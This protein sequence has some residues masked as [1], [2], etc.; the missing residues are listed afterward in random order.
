MRLI[1]G[2]YN[3]PHFPQGSAVTIGAFDGIHLG[4]QAIIEQVVERAKLLALPSVLICFE[5]LPREYFAP[6][7]SP[8][9]ILSFRDKYRVLQDLGIDAVLLINFNHKVASLSAED[10][11]KQVFVQGLNMRYLVVGDDFRFGSNRG[12]DRKM[13]QDYSKTYDFGFSQVS[14][15]THGGERVSS[16]LIRECIENGEFQ[17]ASELLG[18][19]YSVSGQLLAVKPAD[20]KNRASEH[21]SIV[22]YTLLNDAHLVRLTLENRMQFYAVIDPESS[23][24][25]SCLNHKRLFTARLIEGVGNLPKQPVTLEFLYRLSGNQEK[26]VKQNN[27]DGQLDNISRARQWLAESSLI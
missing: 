21:L 4:H 5:P 17:R 7:D 16:T 19:P 24:D 2:V 23:V 3:L 22:C 13:F 9:R 8:L 14:S 11:F 25:R 6:D 18:R 1:R 27:T 10:F 12:G 15:V 26:A 20:H